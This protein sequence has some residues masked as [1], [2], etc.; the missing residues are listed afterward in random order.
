MFPLTPPAGVGVFPFTPPAGVGVFPLTPPAGVGVFPLTPPAG[1][2]VFPLTPPAGVGVLPQPVVELLLLGRLRLGAV[3]AGYARVGPRERP[4]GPHRPV[5]CGWEA[6]RLWSGRYGSRG[7]Y[8]DHRYD[9]A[10]LN[11]NSDRH[12]YTIMVYG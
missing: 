3:H 5:I 4:G 7:N 10:A 12:S 6:G 9:E 11:I 8:V 2:G 1:V